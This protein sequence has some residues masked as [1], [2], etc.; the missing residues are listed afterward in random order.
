[1]CLQR[2]SLLGLVPEREPDS[3]GPRD[4]AAERVGEGPDRA[5]VILVCALPAHPVDR[6]AGAARRRAAR[7]HPAG[8]P[9]VLRDGAASHVRRRARALEFEPLSWLMTL[10]SSPRKRESQRA[11]LSFGTSPAA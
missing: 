1:D 7:L 4:P 11:P 9:S 6:S 10:R 2:N 3:R 8:V 5:D